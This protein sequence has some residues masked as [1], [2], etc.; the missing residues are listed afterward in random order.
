MKVEHVVTDGNSYV[1]GRV[2][3]RREHTCTAEPGYQIST[4]RLQPQV[5]APNGRF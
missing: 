5:Y 3:G 2:V 4:G 1:R